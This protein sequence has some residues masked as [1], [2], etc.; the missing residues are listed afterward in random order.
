MEEIPEFYVPQ[1]ERLAEAFGID[2]MGKVG[3]EL[4]K[5]VINR[6]AVLQSQIRC[7]TDFSSYE[8][9]PEQIE[10]VVVAIASDPASIFYQI[11]LD[12]VKRIAAR[13]I[14]RS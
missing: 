11:P 13:A 7:N 2:A 9:P 6:I 12:S 8:I 14:G 4:L 1:A 3:S 10:S 5:E